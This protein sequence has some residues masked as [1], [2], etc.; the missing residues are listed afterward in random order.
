MRV[1]APASNSM[2]GAGVRRLWAAALALSASAACAAAPLPGERVSAPVVANVTPEA[3]H[4]HDAL[5]PPIPPDPEGDATPEELRRLLA[6]AGPLTDPP[7]LVDGELRLPADWKTLPQSPVLMRAPLGP[8]ALPELAHGT[9]V[10]VDDAGTFEAFDA[11]TGEPL[12]S[13]PPPEGGDVGAPPNRYAVRGCDGIVVLF[14][15]SH[16][17]EGVDA[18]SGQT[19]W[20]VPVTPQPAT[21]FELFRPGLAQR[22]GCHVSYLVRRGTQ[23]LV[24]R[25]DQSLDLRAVDTR[26]G[27]SRLLT[28]C[29]SGCITS[30]DRNDEGALVVH[31]NA[32]R[33]VRFQGTEQ[34]LPRD[35]RFVVDHAS[36][37]VAYDLSTRVWRGVSY[38]GR[39]LWERSRTFGREVARTGDT[40]VG[41]GPG[42]IEALDML[43]GEVLWEVRLE[44]SLRSRFED[45]VP[46]RAADA[47]RVVFASHGSEA[48]P[49][50]VLDGLT[51]RVESL[52][53]GPH[54]GLGTVALEGPWLVIHGYG[55]AA[56]TRIDREAPAIRTH[57]S[58]SED[59][60]RSLAALRHATPG[61][62]GHEDF[63]H[64]L[65]PMDPGQATRW[66]RR[67]G[68]PATAA[69]A[70]VVRG[71]DLT[72]AARA[73]LALPPEGR[74]ALATEA[75]QRSLGAPAE[76]APRELLEAAALAHGFAPLDPRLANALADEAIGWLRDARRRHGREL[77]LRPNCWRS[78][79]ECRELRDTLSKVRVVRDLLARTATD[80][81]PWRRLRAAIRRP[82][83]P[84][85]TP[86]DADGAT[87]AALAY[88][89]EL[90]LEHPSP[91]VVFAEGRSCV[92]AA[93][94]RGHVRARDEPVNH[95][96]PWLVLH[97]PVA[98]SADEVAAE[99]R[100]LDALRWDDD[101]WD[102]APLVWVPYGF[103]V[104]RLRAVAPKLLVANVGGAW[105][106]VGEA[107]DFEALPT[108]PACSGR[109]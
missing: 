88:L 4:E 50:L 55:H 6:H 37:A 35:T 20:R 42:G 30:A 60:R 58:R 32:P 45:F 106:V 64:A 75:L 19:L 25:S 14:T 95:E 28:T 43:T 79:P 78:D 105:R 65:H 66:L 63:E 38:A 103:W 54:W 21:G 80:P 33:L 13:R 57:L 1:T 52:R 89:L 68:P 73:L 102:T 96:A 7:A 84:R 29:P 2:G 94:L 92:G 99:E 90:G 67:L 97:T 3:P 76:G 24:R 82:R 41:L 87:A 56:V 59:I 31:R 70:E 51:G 109:P 11:G 93:T 53:L 44:P 23:T 34:P 48:L 72:H 15:G 12:W 46:G 17:I 49:L 83:R 26:S 98:T 104:L 9:L 107:G 69:L 16:A 71:D 39:L 100:N 8:G 36:V 47:G 27:T 91:E 10:T 62:G 74:R 77:R 22:H 85:C 5:P 81:A 101:A 108:C 86:N 18:R 61:V 40:L